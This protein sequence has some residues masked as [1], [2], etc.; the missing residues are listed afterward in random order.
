MREL[1]HLAGRL[2]PLAEARLSPL[3][4]GFLFGDGVYESLKVLGG[5]PLFLDAHLERL[6]A[7]LLGLRIDAPAGLSAAIAELLEAVGPYDGSLYLQVTRGA[8]PQRSHR[9]PAGLEP[10]LFLLPSPLAFAPDLAAAPPWSAMAR[11]DRRWRRCD[12]KSISLAGA[13]LG[14]L[15]AEA[16]GCDEVLFVGEAGELREGGHTS[17]FA[18]RGE[19]LET[20]P[21]GPEILPGITRALLVEFAR[22]LGLP[23]VER[24][25]RLAERR[26]WS[27]LIACGTL[28]GV[29]GIARLDGE[30]VAG[31]RVGEWTRLLAAS[32]AARERQERE[33]G[34]LW[35]AA[36]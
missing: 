25:P 2:T 8:P 24:A 30:P 7:S 34:V 13:V 1:C 28:T 29:R 9:P 23:L 3:D 27:E 18:R 19:R 31:G 5:V 26:E 22:D 11:P 14:A 16:A 35:K 10:T 4:R 15:D 33:R 12:L 17:L 21:L 36:R 32:L 6:A 20:H